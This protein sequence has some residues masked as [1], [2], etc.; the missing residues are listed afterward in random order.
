NLSPELVA[1]TRFALARALWSRP[2][3]RARARAL[4]KAARAGA[5][6]TTKMTA[7]IDAWLAK[8]S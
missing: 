6:D 8:P 5:G 4:A 3:A 1:E 2:A 7:A